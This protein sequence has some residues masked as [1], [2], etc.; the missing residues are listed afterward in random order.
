VF[1]F[2]LL[3]AF[4]GATHLLKFIGTTWSTGADRLGWAL[5]LTL[6]VTGSTHFSTPEPFLAM[7]PPWLPW[8]LELVYLSGAAELII[9]VGLFSRRWRPAAALAAAALF[10]AV[11]PANLH[12]AVSGAKIPNYPASPV[13]RW[14][15]LPMQGVL[16]GW[17]IWV[18]RASRGSRNVHS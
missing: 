15:R 18:W 7:M 17:A 12:A 6:L 9:G 1:V 5:G 8:H 11:F 14:A 16:I 2:V 4:F 13:Y 3:L 10:L